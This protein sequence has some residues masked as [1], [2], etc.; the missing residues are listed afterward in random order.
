MHRHQFKAKPFKRDFNNDGLY[1]VPLK[2]TFE[3]TRPMT[4]DFASKKVIKK[5]EGVNDEQETSHKD[6]YRQFRAQPMPDFTAVKV[7]VVEWYNMQVTCLPHSRLKGSES[8]C[9]GVVQH[10]C[11]MPDFKAVKV[12]EVEWYNI[13][14]TCQTSGQ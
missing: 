13:L 14:V 7:S 4:P 3:L 11:D 8:E 1:G 12:S 9:S 6:M 5:R 10:A 2:R